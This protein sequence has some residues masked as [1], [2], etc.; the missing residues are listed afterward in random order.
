MNASTIAQLIIA[1]GPMALEIIP[2][3]MAVWN[4]RELT[5]A[6]VLKICQVSEKPY[7]DYVKPAA[8]S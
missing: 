4:V 1:L 8:V 3:L 5:P 2:K 7:E 6:E